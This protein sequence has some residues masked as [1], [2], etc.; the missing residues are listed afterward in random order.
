VVDGGFAYGDAPA[1]WSVAKT[2]EQALEIAAASAQPG[3][4]AASARL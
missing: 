1:L 3:P 4:R 2:P